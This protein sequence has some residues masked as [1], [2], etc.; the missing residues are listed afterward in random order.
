MGRWRGAGAEDHRA[1]AAALLRTSTQDFAQLRLGELS[2]GQRQRVLL[3]RALAQGARILLLDEPTASLDPRYQAET[4]SLVRDLVTEGYAA[5]LITH[6][7]SWA[8]AFATRVVVLRGGRVAVQ[9]SPQ[10]VL[11]REALEPVYGP[12][13][14]YGKDPRGAGPIVIPWLDSGS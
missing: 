13:L 7:L 1:V 3:A 2:G 8:S 14:W 11:C 10:E 9:G 5:L 4:L 12:H 6:E